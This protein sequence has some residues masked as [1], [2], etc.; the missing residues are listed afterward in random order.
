MYMVYIA[1]TQATLISQYV[2]TYT[3]NAHCRC[4]NILEYLYIFFNIT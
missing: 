1:Q 2:I 3:D 4:L